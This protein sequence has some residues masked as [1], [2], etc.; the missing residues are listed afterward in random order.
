MEEKKKNTI[1][2]MQAKME[3]PVDDETDIKIKKHISVCKN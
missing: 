3:A 1:D 2:S